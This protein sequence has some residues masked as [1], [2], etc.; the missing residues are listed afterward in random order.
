MLTLG[1]GDPSLKLPFWMDLGGK[2]DPQLSYRYIYIVEDM[3]VHMSHTKG[4]S[5]VWCKVSHAVTLAPGSPPQLRFMYTIVMA[6]RRGLELPSTLRY[7]L[8]IF[9]VFAKFL[10]LAIITW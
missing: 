10:V 5:L 1:H 8:I 2:Y 6:A 9:Q 7:V 4:M 3:D